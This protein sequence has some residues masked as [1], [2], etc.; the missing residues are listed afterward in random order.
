MKITKAIIFY[1]LIAI[2]IDLILIIYN[3]SKNKI[4][5]NS[6]TKTELIL[7]INNQLKKS[8]IPK[9]KA[10]II[11]VTRIPTKVNIPLVFIES[12]ASLQSRKC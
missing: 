11:P 1:V 3:K 2:S 8:L 6:A 10:P 4:K 7:V 9:T 12:D 5:L